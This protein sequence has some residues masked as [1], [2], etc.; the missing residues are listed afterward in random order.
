MSPDGRPKEAP[1]WLTSA[2]APQSRLGLDMMEPTKRAGLPIVMVVVGKHFTLLL[3]VF[4][5]F[6]GPWG[7]SVSWGAFQRS[8]L[9]GHRSKRRGA[10]LSLGAGPAQTRNSQRGG[11]GAGGRLL[12]RNSAA[13]VQCYTIYNI[14]WNPK[15]AGACLFS[16]PYVDV[17]PYPPCP[18]Q[19]DPLKGNSKECMNQ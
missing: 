18:Y 15:D 12:P 7:K 2:L 10:G 14:K 17:V 8:R 3:I 1:S 13:W 16:K 4:S 19:S 6:A 9:R 5:G 11:T